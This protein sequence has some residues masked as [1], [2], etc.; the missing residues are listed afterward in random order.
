MAEIGKKEYIDWQIKKQSTIGEKLI[1][2]LL[3]RQQIN[4]FQSIEK[5]LLYS[6]N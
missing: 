2:T 5:R 1:P 4:I 3:L 6:G